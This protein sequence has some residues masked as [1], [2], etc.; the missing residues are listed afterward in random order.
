MATRAAIRD[1]VRQQ[2]LV[3]EDDWAD[4]KVNAVINQGLYVLSTRFEWPWLAATDTLSVI[5]GTSSYTM[6]ADLARS[7]AITRSDKAQR[8]VEVSPHQILGVYG[9]DLPTGDPTAY[10]VHGR[11]LYL[12]KIPSTSASYSWLYYKQPSTLDNDV[13]EPTF[14]AEFHLV[15]ADYAIAKVWEREEDFT[16][17]DDAMKDFDQ[18]VESMAIYYLDVSPDRPVVF[19]GRNATLSRYP[20][21]PWLD[22]V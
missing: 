18:G 5:A 2:T 1:Y 21:M 15:L 17:A 13:D 4:S 12:D 6:P 7:R 11:T 22:G 10:Y 20:N 14:A 3:E 9:G 8:L 19:G 16:K